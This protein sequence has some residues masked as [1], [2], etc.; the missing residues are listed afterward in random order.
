MVWVGVGGME[1]LGLVVPAVP[2]GVVPVAHTGMTGGLDFPEA[3]LPEEVLAAAAAVI[4]TMV[5]P[6]LSLVQAVREETE[7]ALYLTWG[8]DN[9]VIYTLNRRLYKSRYRLC[10]QNQS[11]LDLLYLHL[12]NLRSRLNQLHRHQQQYPLK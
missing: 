8:I 2:V 12:L 5:N 7:F 4:M 10:R 6:V 9:R 11:H 3:L 1:N